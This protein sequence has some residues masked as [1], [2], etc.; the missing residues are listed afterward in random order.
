[1]NTQETIK[2][3]DEQIQ[4][5]QHLVTKCKSSMLAPLGSLGDCISISRAYR[6]NLEAL[7]RWKELRAFVLEH[8]K[9]FPEVG[10]LYAMKGG[11]AFEVRNV[12]GNVVF[13]QIIGGLKL[14]SPEATWT[15]SSFKEQCIEEVELRGVK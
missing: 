5:Y 1:M 9:P 15:I 7:K 6:N 2:M 11:F 3:I 10:K 13:G 4:F 14:H 8:S 12:D